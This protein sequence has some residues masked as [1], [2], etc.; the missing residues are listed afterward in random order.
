MQ[1]PPPPGSLDEAVDGV[2]DAA[3]SAGSAAGTAVD[4]GGTA[5]DTGTTNYNGIYRTFQHFPFRARQ[6]GK[7]K[8]CCDRLF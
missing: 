5:V 4:V 7:V 8:K 3:G 2:G 1:V 6:I